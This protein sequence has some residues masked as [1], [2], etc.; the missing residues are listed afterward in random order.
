[1]VKPLLHLVVHRQMDPPLQTTQFRHMTAMEM[2]FQVQHVQVP[3][4][5]AQLLVL[6]MDL[7]T[8]LKL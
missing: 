8:H 3:Q 2:L 1:M 5:L 7:S 4:V 6:Q